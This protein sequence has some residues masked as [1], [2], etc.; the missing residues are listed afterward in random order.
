MNVLM[1][2]HVFLKPR[3]A[4]MNPL[5][6]HPALLG[7]TLLLRALQAILRAQTVRLVSTNPVQVDRLVNRV[8]KENLATN[9]TPHPQ[10]HR[11]I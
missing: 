8:R 1:V 10:D 3:P 5:R 6:A 2:I 7:R 4:Q 9:T 11:P